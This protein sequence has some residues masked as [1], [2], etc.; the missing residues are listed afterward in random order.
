MERR[1]KMSKIISNS[2]TVSSLN[3]TS[4][5]GSHSHVLEDLIHT[6]G[7]LFFSLGLATGL[8]PPA[9]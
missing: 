4:P 3:G 7:H 6:H 8:S 2:N 5:K 1:E 9:E